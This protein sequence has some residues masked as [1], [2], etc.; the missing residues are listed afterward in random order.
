LQFAMVRLNPNKLRMILAIFNSTA[1]QIWAE[2]FTFERCFEGSR[3]VFRRILAGIL[4]V[5]GSNFIKRAKTTDEEMA[6][7]IIEHYKHQTD[8]YLQR[9]VDQQD[10][11][12]LMMPI[13]SSRRT[14]LLDPNPFKRDNVTDAEFDSLEKIIYAKFRRDEEYWFPGIQAVC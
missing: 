1:E 2:I 7:K 4:A 11:N 5:V 13:A 9:E 14:S 10:D 12:E 6:H 3:E 8:V